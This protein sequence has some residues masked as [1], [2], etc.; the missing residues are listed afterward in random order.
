MDV[1]LDHYKLRVF[2][3]IDVYIY[4]YLGY[5]LSVMSHKYDCPY[6]CKIIVTNPM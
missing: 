5:A 3:I 2:R 1:I 6:T 4:I